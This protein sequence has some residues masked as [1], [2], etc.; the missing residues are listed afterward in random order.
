MNAQMEGALPTLPE[1]LSRPA[2]IARIRATM[3]SLTDDE[4]C[5]CSVAARYGVLCGGFTKLPDKDFRSRFAWIASKRR[6]ATREELEQYVSAYHLGRQE[7]QKAAI[8]C[9]VETREHCVCDGW[10]QFDNADI[11]RFC[12]EVTGSRV[13]V[14]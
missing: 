2:A 10:N 14:G 12:L 11:E 5:A 6:G 3:A 13:S 8:C 9:D 7:T 1:R 4:N